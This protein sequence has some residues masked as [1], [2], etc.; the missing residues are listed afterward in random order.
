MPVKAHLLPAERTHTHT[1]TSDRRARREDFGDGPFVSVHGN[2]NHN[3]LCYSV[4]SECE[5]GVRVH[6]CVI[7]DKAVI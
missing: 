4:C 6:A 5:G 1:H 3:I 2:E 7:G